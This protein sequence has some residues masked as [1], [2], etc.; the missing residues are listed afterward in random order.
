MGLA[1]SYSE[2]FVTFPNTVPP[3]RYTSH[4][5]D[6]IANIIRIHTSCMAVP[7][8]CHLTASDVDMIVQVDALEA[9]SLANLM[10]RYLRKD[11]ESLFFQ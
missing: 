4:D 6:D 1:T 2:L 7:I 3:A 5:N 10:T 8:Q 9:C 11:A